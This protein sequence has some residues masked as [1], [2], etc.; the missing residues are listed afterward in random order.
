VDRDKVLKQGVAPQRC[1]PKP[2]RPHGRIFNHYFNRF[3]RQWPGLYRGEGED[4]A[5]V[6]NVG[7]VLVRKQKG[8]NVRSPH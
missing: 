6:E 4:R 2:F 1:L 5:K 3:G 7:T 8:E